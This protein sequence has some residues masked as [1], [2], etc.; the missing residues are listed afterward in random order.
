M[1]HDL[2]LKEF[3]LDDGLI[4]LN[5][6]AVAPWPARTREAVRQFAEEICRTGA[7]HYMT[8]MQKET[9][10]RGQ[11]QRLLNAPAIADIALLKNTSEALSVVASGL[12]WQAGDNVVTSAEEFPS[13][14]L[15]WQ[16]LASQGVHLKEVDI[17]VAEPEAALIG[18]CDQHTR[19]LT[20]SSVQYGS[21]IRLDL[22]VLGQYCRR[23]GILFCVDA[24]QS[25]GAICMDVQAIQADF[26]M[27][28]AH[29][30]MLG[31]EGAALFYSTPSARDQ[32]QLHQHG[33]HMVETVDFNAREWQPARS[34]RRFECGTPNTLGIHAM[35][36]SLSLLEEVGYP[37]VEAR[38]LD[39]SAYLIEKLEQIDAVRVLT[40][41]PEPRHAGIISFTVEGADLDQLHEKLVSNKVLCV[42]RGGGIR[43]SPHF[44]IGRDK[45]DKAVEILSAAI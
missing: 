31:P 43:F 5:H 13:N 30:W 33:W 15:P 8:W 18:S 41:R 3:P 10:L 2:L 35:S 28:D 42:H 14:R 29:K 27:A 24:I 1:N 38:I 36:A 9:E 40:P 25:L 32:L 26:V 44:Y 22:E 11:I 6:A 34:A 20:I 16:A 12:P 45:L 37:Q 21:G 17:K 39:N 19:V 4:Y 23:Q 7:Q